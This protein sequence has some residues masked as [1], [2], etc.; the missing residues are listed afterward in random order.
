MLNNKNFKTN[1]KYKLII[2]LAA[3]LLVSSPFFAQKK[4]SINGVISASGTSN[5]HDWIVKTDQF[6]GTFDINETNAVTN[7]SV[8]IPVASLKS[9]LTSGFERKQ[10]ENLVLKTFNHSKNPTIVFEVNDEFTPAIK[11]NEADVTLTGNLS[12]AGVTK[13]ISFKSTGVKLSN[14][15]YKFTATI[16][17]TFTEYGMKPPT[18]LIVMKVKDPLILK[19][20]ITI[21]Q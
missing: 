11:G 15:N 7:L 16:P 19:L 9:T 12:M 20:D 5:T 21:S 8:K 1:M 13:R 14:G 6:S 10:M 3:Y 2:T 18:A 17:M 4:G